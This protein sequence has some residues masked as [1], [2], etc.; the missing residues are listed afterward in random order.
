MFY[1]IFV[2]LF[3]K[4]ILCVL[5]ASLSCGRTKDV[6]VVVVVPNIS[7]RSAE[8]FS[9]KKSRSFLS[10][11]VSDISRKRGRAADRWGGGRNGFKM[12]S[13][14]IILP[15]FLRQEPEI[16]SDRAA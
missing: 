7:I 1:E 12:Q 13:L 8:I 15:N 9:N 2:F 11:V 10:G 5:F 4:L 3:V 6:V 14:N 16:S